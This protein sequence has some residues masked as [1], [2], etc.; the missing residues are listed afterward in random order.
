[1]LIKDL[2]NFSQLNVPKLI[3]DPYEADLFKIN[4]DLQTDL[5]HKIKFSKE[6]YESS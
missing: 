1:M 2:I 3:I 6:I 5:E 4:V